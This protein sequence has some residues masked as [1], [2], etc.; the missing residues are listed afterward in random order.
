MIRTIIVFFFI[1]C[2][3]Y[4]DGNYHAVKGGILSHSNGFISS[5]RES[6]YDVNVELQFKEKLLL[7]HYTTGADINT[8]NDTSFLYGGLSWEGR[9]FDNLL[10][11]A[12]LGAA[13]HNGELDDGSSDKRQLGSRVTFRESLDIGFYLKKNISVSLMWDHYSNLGIRGA[14]NQGNDNIGIRIG[15]YF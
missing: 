7:G 15:Y 9:F 13:I 1:F 12:F 2:F 11:G 10:I 6:G 8:N 5:G 3:S 14:S 4:A